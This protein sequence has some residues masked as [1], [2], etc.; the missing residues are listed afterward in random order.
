VS[1][2]GFGQGEF[3]RHSFGEWKWSKRTLYEFLPE[4]HKLEDIGTGGQLEAFMAALQGPFDDLRRKIRDFGNLRDPDLVRSA[5]NETVNVRL[6]KKVLAPGSVEQRGLDGKV[7][8]IEFQSVTARFEEGDLGKEISLSRSKI[9][10]N[11]TTVRIVAITSKTEVV[12]EP[13]LPNDTGPLRWE[14]RELLSEEDLSFIVEVRGGD[15]NKIAPG[16]VI[17]DGLGQFEIL[18]RNQY[19]L[20]AD[21]LAVT[22]RE[23]EDSLIDSLGHLRSSNAAFLPSDIGKQLVLSGSQVPTN[24]TRY[25]IFDTDAVSVAAT[26]IITLV[27]GAFMVDG[28]TLTLNDGT[29]PPQTFE[30]DSNASVAFG[31]V[32]V[33]FTSTQ[34]TSEIRDALKTAID[35]VSGILDI[36]PSVLS[37]TQLSLLHTSL[38]TIGNAVITDTVADPNFTTTGMSGGRIER[39]A[40]FSRL[41]IT[42]EASSFTIPGLSATPNAGDVIYNVLLNAPTA[43]KV[44]IEHVQLGSNTPLSVSTFGNKVIVNLATDG[45]GA[46]ISD[47]AD[48]LAAVRGDAFTSTRVAITARGLITVTS[49]AGVTDGQ[50][51]TIDDGVNPA[52]VFEFDDNG[53]VVETPTLRGV[54]FSGIDTEDQIRDALIAAINT[55]PTLNINT[56]IVDSDTLFLENTATT[57]AID[58]LISTTTTFNT[59]DFSEIVGS[60]LPRFFGDVDPSGSVL[61]ELKPRVTGILVQHVR[62]GFNTPLTVEVVNNLVTVNL[63]TNNYGV[64]VSTATSVAAAV[65][66]DPEANLLLRSQAIAGGSGTVGISGILEVPGKTPDPDNIKL[67]WSILHPAKIKVNLQR[68]TAGV[69]DQQGIDGQILSG[70]PVKFTSATA[71]FSS[72][73]V[74]KLLLLRGSLIGNDGIYSIKAVPTPDEIEI[75]G[76]LLADSG[77]TWSIREPTRIGDGTQVQVR[78]PSLLELLAKDFGIEVS[79]DNTEEEQRRWVRSVSKWVDRKGSADSYSILSKAGGFEASAERLMRA[80]PSQLAFLPPESITEM[81]EG[82]VGKS[83]V[84]GRLYLSGSELLFTANTSLFSASD[85]G[86]QMRL[87]NCF[88]TSNNGLYTV[89]RVESSNTVV[90]RSEGFT[91]ISPDD[92]IIGEKLI[93]APG[94]V[95]TALIGDFINEEVFSLSDGVNLPKT[96]EFDS[97]QTPG[98]SAGNIPLFYIDPANPS[99]TSVASFRDVVVSEIANVT[100]NDLLLTV[101]QGL[102][103]N[104]VHIAYTNTPRTG[105]KI[106]ETADLT[107]SPA[108]IDVQPLQAET[109]NPKIQWNVVRLYTT[110]VPRQPFTDDLNPDVM[111]EIIDG[112]PAVGTITVGDGSTLSDG[113]WFT[114]SDGVDSVTFEFE[115][116]LVPGLITGTV[117]I[118]YEDLTATLILVTANDVR[119]AI[120]K[121]INDDTTLQ[122]HAVSNGDGQLQITNKYGGTHG[123][124]TITHAV[125]APGWAVTGMSGGTGPD[126]GQN[127]FG[128]DKMCF[129]LDFLAEFDVTILNP[130]DLQPKFLNSLTYT[131]TV[132]APFLDSGFNLMD[133][134]VSLGPWDLQI[135]KGTAAATSQTGTGILSSAGTTVTGTGTIFRTELLVGSTIT[136]DL[137]TRTVIDITN[138]TTLTVDSPWTLPLAAD[139]FTH[140]TLPDPVTV[141]QSLSMETLP[142]NL[143]G[144]RYSFEVVTN[145]PPTVFPV[146]ARIKYNCPISF[147]C[148]F[149]GSNRIKLSVHDG[150]NIRSFD[151]H[152][153]RITEVIPAHLRQL[154]IRQQSVEGSLSL[155]AAGTATII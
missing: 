128:V 105:V 132:T 58:L 74:G 120:I 54:I 42:G 107:V 104:E 85:V 21:N 148:E 73:D 3:G 109:S 133:A 48:V 66:A 63:G 1:G 114:I 13:T 146:S 46:I 83:G 33:P 62:S 23:G 124:V 143:G 5:F 88:T 67:L 84:D 135:L 139:L 50:T 68:G 38:G 40:V 15:P 119:D 76:V 102:V 69:V 75:D 57:G 147:F 43:N 91:A 34:A 99:P 45:T 32:A 98:V 41:R 70:L 93:L 39:R 112:L 26:G 101:T 37:A 123:N 72:S 127:A 2:G 86:L 53:S 28:E 108:N 59:I 116:E 51:I 153:Q 144:G 14:L 17:T 110:V 71:S 10:G 94:S 136:A 77:L 87:D 6:G 56:D 92:G 24:N 25:E 8:G 31:N 30:F 95:P 36:T 60:S 140:V 154:L 47:V 117:P 121:A 90:L 29:N 9:P 27:G 22:E 11:N 111:E 115:R 52:V 80:A 35:S 118:V 44:Q 89:L 149:C 141:G 12:V 55:A 113:E 100:G 125:T 103:F 142:V 61:Y 4:F 81:A 64:T 96:F 122:V 20:N 97:S 152:L 137:E 129:E 151:D 19:R 78:A 155:I 134:V 130:S 131:A 65:N 145:N 82:A 7:V 16:Y 49:G 18:S 126:F 150:P 138:D 106:L 79:E